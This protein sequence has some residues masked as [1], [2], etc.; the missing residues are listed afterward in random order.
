MYIFFIGDNPPMLSEEIIVPEHKPIEGLIGDSSKTTPSVL[1]EAL[2]EVNKLQLAA[3]KL[4]G[5]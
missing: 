5:N 2:K 3:E 4:G 1:S